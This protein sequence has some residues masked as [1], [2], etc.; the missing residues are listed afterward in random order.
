MLT[1]S[2][3]GDGMTLR[4]QIP[5]REYNALLVLPRDL[6]QQEASRLKAFIDTL[7]IPPPAEASGGEE[8]P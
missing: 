6:T 3:P 7:V 1:I 4:Y 5:I 8:E 2:S